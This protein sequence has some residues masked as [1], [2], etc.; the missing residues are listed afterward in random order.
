[1]DTIP[2]DHSSAYII[3]ID[4][5]KL[6]AFSVTLYPCDHPNCQGDDGS[7]PAYCCRG[8]FDPLT[9]DGIGRLRHDWADLQGHVP[10]GAED[11]E[12]RLLAEVLRVLTIEENGVD[13]N[14]QIPGLIP[15]IIHRCAADA[16]YEVYVRTVPSIISILGAEGISLPRAESI[17]DRG[18]GGSVG[19]YGTDGG[20]EVDGQVTR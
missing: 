11:I 5:P 17:L 16:L 8:S 7:M 9:S 20:G 1:M 3:T 10:I 6:A 2:L 13:R 15:L 4:D 19:H 14:I 12:C 18:E